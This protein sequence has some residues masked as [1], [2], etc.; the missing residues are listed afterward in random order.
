MSIPLAVAPSVKSPGLF[1]VVN[2][3]AGQSS[4]GSGAFR[5][6]MIAGKSAS[7]TITE[8]T[9]IQ[10]AVAGAEAVGTFLGT[11]MPGHLAA[12]ALFEEHGLATVDLIAPTAAAGVV[13]TGTATFA[14]GPPTVSQ[15]VNVWIAGVRTQIVWAAG[16]TDTQGGDTLE[17]AVN[18][19]PNLPV[20]AANVAGVVTFT[21]KAAGTWGNDIKL[22]ITV[23]D[24]A[25]GTVTASGTS[26]AAGTTE[27]DAT[28]ALALVTQREYNLILI[29]TS[30]ADAEDGTATSNPGIVKTHIDGLDEGQQAK[31]QQLVVGATGTLAAIKTG[32][33]AMNFGRGQAVFMNNGEALPAQIAGAEVGARLRE[34][35]LDAAANRI[36][37]EYRAN[38]P[39][40]VNRSAD[41]LTEVQIEDALNN[42]VTPISFTAI[43]DPR[44]ERPITMYHLDAAGNPDA[45]LLDTSRVTGT[46]AVAKDLRITIPIEF[47]QAKLSPDLEGFGDELPAGVVEVR[48]IKS[49]IDGRVRFWVSLGVVQF[50]AYQDAVDNGTFIVRVNPSDSS[51]ADIVLPIK[52]VPPLAKFSLV[53]Q[54]IGP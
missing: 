1:L 16:E 7:G 50:Q 13:A 34:E 36:R 33:D 29:C 25:G 41:E 31:L 15:T 42:G 47:A 38:F 9:E 2:L 21:A 43:G 12:I 37:L 11:G 28:V 52:I 19:N 54:H 23:E 10:E 26:L 30:N 35:T 24:G 18:G 44:V 53:V 46:D 49:F 17:A 51:Q 14:A 5:A 45:R 48:D 4:P 39:T 20:T 6:L 27:F 40:V 8:D 32:V 3:L 22:R